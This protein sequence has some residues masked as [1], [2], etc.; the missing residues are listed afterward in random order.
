MAGAPLHKILTVVWAAGGASAAARERTQAAAQLA[1]DMKAE[2]AVLALGLGTGTVAPALAVAGANEILV[3]EEEALQVAPGEAGLRAIERACEL[4][5]ADLVLLPADSLG[6]DWAPRL[7]YRLGAGLVTEV[8]DWSLAAGRPIFERLVF[9]GKAIATMVVAEGRAVAATR[10]GAG[11]RD[12]PPPSGRGE[13]RALG[14]PIP[15]D[16]LWPRVVRRQSEEREGPG[17]DEARVIVSGGRGLGGPEGF[18][19]LGDLAAA[20]GGALGASRAAVDEGWAP[21]TWQIGQT[22]KTVAPEL[23]IAVGISG[24]SQHLVG[25]SKAKTIVAINSDPDAP[26]FDYARFGVVGDW[27]VIVPALTAAVKEMRDR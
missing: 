12:A 23:Y 1:A 27:R 5:G 16:P 15:L 4:T 9:G 3:S 6:R 17:L 21:A 10:P 20:L 13:V 24:A 18:A 22:G 11:R 7:A 8:T 25:C 26:I 2:F 14:L 19:R